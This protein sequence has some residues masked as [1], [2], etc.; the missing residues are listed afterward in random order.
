[1]S[2]FDNSE[3]DGGQV[4]TATLGDVTVKKPGNSYGPLNPYG[5]LTPT[6]P[7]LPP[8]SAYLNLMRDPDAPF[9]TPTTLSFTNV[10]RFTNNGGDTRWG[11][12]STL[13]GCKQQTFLTEPDFRHYQEQGE[14]KY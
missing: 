5:L 2:G 7:L 6:N 12:F 3:N 11:T 4:Q 9:V 8:R 14:K 10:S 13:L 1:M